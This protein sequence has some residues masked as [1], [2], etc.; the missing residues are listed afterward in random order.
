MLLR[1]QQGREK[2]RNAVDAGLADENPERLEEY[3]GD[4]VFNPAS[5]G[6]WFKRSF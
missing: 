4:F 2:V 1:W 5:L 6:Q 3:T